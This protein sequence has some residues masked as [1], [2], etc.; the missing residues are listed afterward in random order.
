MLFKR[1]YI[2]LKTLQV[3]ADCADKKTPLFNVARKASFF[4]SFRRMAHSKMEASFTLEAAVGMPVLIMAVC[5]F[6]WLIMV[7]RLQIS[8][9]GAMWEVAEEL[10]G[11][12]YLYEQIRNMDNDEAE[13]IRLNETGI[14]RW[15][16]G[17]ITEEYIEERLAANIGRDSGIWRL[18]S[19]GADGIEVKSMYGIPDMAGAIDIVVVYE[20]VNPF[21][22]VPAGG[23]KLVQRCYL[24]AWLGVDFRD[25]ERPEEFAYVA[26]TGQVY[27]IYSD[28]TYL[29]PNVK[30]AACNLG[31]VTAAENKIYKPCEVCIGKGFAVLTNVAVYVS[32]TGDKYHKDISCRTLKRTVYEIPLDEA[33]KK[34]RK[35]IRCEKREEKENASED[36]GAYIFGNR[37]SY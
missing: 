7:F 36:N 33:V 22:P 5:S 2:S 1:L 10:S 15:L 24:K 31:Y 37:Y 8:L 11:Y 3:Q 34:Y 29:K 14:E 12:A 4:P 26:E 20:A 28:C 6:F 18:I 9:Q 27:H 25:E 13:Y 17:G 21:I 16:V 30:L 35:C 19:G 32:D 23:I